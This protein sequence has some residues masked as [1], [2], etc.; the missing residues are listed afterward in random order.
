M[1]IPNRLGVQMPQRTTRRRSGWLILPAAV[2]SLAAGA[3]DHRL[4]DAVERRDTR[5]IDALL[6][7]KTEV[8][9]PQP[10]GASPLHWAAHYDD[11]A[12]VRR[13]IAA[14]ANANA[15]NDHGVTP[16]AL[17]CENGNAA[18]TAA[19]LSA[20]ARP[21]DRAASGETPL[22]IAV[23]SGAYDVVDALLA[24]GADVNAA[25]LSHQQ[26]ALMWAVARG[27][28]RIVERLIA[29]GADVHARSRVRRRTVQL[30]TRYGDQNTVRGVTEMDLGG[31]TP[32]L[33]AARSGTVAS[34]AHLLGAGA[35]ANDKAPGGMSAL[36]VAAHS[37]N[38]A[39][40]AYLAEHGAD[41]NVADAGYTALH[42]AILR[43]DLPL[44]QVLVA[45][46]ADPNAVLA[47]GTPSRYYS[48]DYAFNENLVGA[49]PL[50]LAARFGEPEMMRALVAG[51][52]DPRWTMKD[53]ATTLMSAIVPTRGLGTFRAGDRRERYQG[54]AD[55]AAKGDG[56]DEEIT[57]RTAAAALDLGADVNA[58]TTEG[59]TALHLAASLAL[60]KVVQLLVDRGAR[61]DVMN[62]RELTPLGMAT[63][64]QPRGPL[65]VFGLSADERK[66]TA[67]L[68][69]RLGATK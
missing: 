29:A 8:N 41:V 2:L 36:V 51:G 67:D 33:F 15:A 35:N 1:L 38:G 63:S 13:L 65:G 48:K 61:L 50:W 24:R 42:A 57:L 19:L 49:S 34:A 66:P 14:G 62:K 28:D 40:A 7:R 18:I 53:G 30:N 43:G 12:L 55:V 60:N 21:N 16:L 44:V 54:P 5:T 9:A 4:A 22:M 47:K 64:N 11:L 68:L 23:R 58:V 56:E 69:R 52:A 37:G 17:A 6:A 27:H 25:E 10:D 45:R 26:T 31:F 39:V 46:G 3:A 59:D 32:L 20:G